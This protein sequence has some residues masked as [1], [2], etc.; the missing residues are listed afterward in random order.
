MECI[1]NY[2][3]IR[4]SIVSVAIEKS[5]ESLEG[6]DV[7]E[8]VKLGTAELIS[9]IEDEKVL[10]AS[11]FSFDYRDHLEVLVSRISAL[12]YDSLRPSIIYDLNIEQLSEICHLLKSNSTGSGLDDMLHDA[13][14]KLVFRC[15]NYFENEIV[16]YNG[17]TGDITQFKE[18][19]GELFPPVSKLFFLFKNLYQRVQV[20][21]KLFGFTKSSV[22]DDVSQELMQ[23]VM[24]KVI[25]TGELIKVAEPL[26]SYLFII[27]NLT[28]IKDES[29]KLKGTF[30]RRERSLDLNELRDAALELLKLQNTSL[31]ESQLVKEIEWNSKKNLAL[32]L[33]RYIDD[34]IIYLT[35]LVEDPIFEFNLKVK[36]AFVVYNRS[37]H[38]AFESQKTKD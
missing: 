28:L 31:F 14:Q 36:P 38:S 8:I 21:Y 15:Q 34:L 33:K 37:R 18:R 6:K 35:K 29:S 30:V 25:Q 1:N 24:S 27:R 16:P 3:A 2:S 32:Q 7:V 22:F 17:S 5:I 20:R 4:E 26:V 9:I 23:I 13:Q 12:F 11:F 19:P 10:F